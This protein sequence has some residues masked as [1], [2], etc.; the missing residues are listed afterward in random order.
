MWI[1]VGFLLLAS[2]TQGVPVAEDGGSVDMS[3]FST[4]TSSMSNLNGDTHQ[5][6]YI[7]DGAEMNGIPTFGLNVERH[8]E[9]DDVQEDW[10]VLVPETKENGEESTMVE[11]IDFYESGDDGTDGNELKPVMDYMTYLDYKNSKDYDE[12]DYQ[13]PDYNDDD[14][15]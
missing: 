4:F 1:F 15:E 2:C 7:Q 9:N 11:P 5:D 12:Y 3:K 10:D 6:S 14:D 8:S 13:D